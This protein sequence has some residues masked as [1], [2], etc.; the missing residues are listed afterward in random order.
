MKHI[1]HLPGLVL[2]EKAWQVQVAARE[3]EIIEEDE[4]NDGI[5][6]DDDEEEEETFVVGEINPSSYIHMGTPIFWLPLNPDW[7]AKISYKGNIDL[8][9]QNRKENPRLVEKE[10]VIDYKFHTAFQQDFYEFVIIT[11]T[12][13]VAISQWIDWTYMEG[14]HDRIFDGV[15]AACRA[16]HLRDVMSFKRIGI[17]RSLLNSLPHYMLRRGGY[18]EVSLDDRGEAV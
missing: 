4:G 16:K 9:W 2:M 15:V 11:K 12:K 1:G 5:D 3:E 14:M 13:S 7:R 8:V 10:P 17:T 6:G 18:K